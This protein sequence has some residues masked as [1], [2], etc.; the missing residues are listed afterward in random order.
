MDRL[1][2]FSIRGPDALLGPITAV[3]LDEEEWIVRVLGIDIGSWWEEKHA[4]IPPSEVTTISRLQQLMHVTITQ[5]DLREAPSLSAARLDT[6]GGSKPTEPAE[7]HNCFVADPKGDLYPG[8]MNAMSIPDRAIPYEEPPV[9]KPAERGTHPGWR[10]QRHTW[11]MRL[12]DNPFHIGCPLFYYL[13]F[14]IR[15]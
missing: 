3:V 7:L 4:F 12:T 1:I 9:G 10:S 14:M 11:R 15:T 5:E 8:S 2:G 6:P 13:V